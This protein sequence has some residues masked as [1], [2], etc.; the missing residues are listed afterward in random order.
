MDRGRRSALAGGIAL[1]LGGVL[2]LI[3]QIVPGWEG[4]LEWPMFV[5]GVG[6]LLLVI[7]LVTGATGMAIPACVVGGIGGILYYQNAS[8]DWTSW[9]FAWSLIPGFV[10][11][12]I[13]LSGLFE[14]KLRRQLREGGQL[15]LISLIMFTIAGSLSGALGLSGLGEYW[16]VLLIALGVL[17][18]LGRLF[19]RQPSLS[20]PSSGGDTCA[21]APSSGEPPSS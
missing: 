5:I 11:V 1:I 15:I 4:W 17:I 16:P 6:V 14:G 18:L 9:S 19:P 20:E 10:G 8:D 7:G 3:I 21:K 2:F 12:G 13:I